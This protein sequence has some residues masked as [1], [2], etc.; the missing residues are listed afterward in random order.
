MTTLKQKLRTFKYARQ[1]LKEWGLVKDVFL[2]MLKDFGDDFRYLFV[3]YLFE[4]GTRIDPDQT[5]HHD[6]GKGE[7]TYVDNRFGENYLTSFKSE[8]EE[9]NVKEL[10]KELLMEMENDTDLKKIVGL[11]KDFHPYLIEEL[12]G[13]LLFAMPW[14]DNSVKGIFSGKEE[15]TR[16]LKEFEETKDEKK[17]LANEVINLKMN[18]GFDKLFQDE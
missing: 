1:N 4:V 11:I 14:E 10:C 12:L 7:N 15:L 5:P 17:V 2:K 6:S 18:M 13:I 9:L 3:H 16:R 8:F